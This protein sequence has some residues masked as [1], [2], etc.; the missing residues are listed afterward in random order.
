MT[1]FFWSLLGTTPPTTTKQQHIDLFLYVRKPTFYSS[2]IDVFNK[3]EDHYELRTLRLWLP[4]PMMSF[5]YFCSNTTSISFV[6]S[7]LLSSF[8]WFVHGGTAFL[9]WSLQGTRTPTT[10]TN[11]Q[12]NDKF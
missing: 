7:F 10:T 4:V 8:W 11:Q 3:I 5:S 1:F 12:H 2:F 9:F 6:H